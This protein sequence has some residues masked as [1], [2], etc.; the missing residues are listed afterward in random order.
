VRRFRSIK[1]PELFQAVKAVESKFHY[2]LL[3]LEHQEV[4]E[5]WSKEK[6]NTIKEIDISLRLSSLGK[7]NKG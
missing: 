3:K 2:F 5:I 6:N 7:C 1:I 4:D